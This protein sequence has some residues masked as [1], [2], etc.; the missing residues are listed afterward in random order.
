[1]HL[2]PNRHSYSALLGEE[3][4]SSL[5]LSGPVEYVLFREA[6]NSVRYCPL[7]TLLYL[8]YIFVISVRK[9]KKEEEKTESMKLMM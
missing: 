4:E 3:F 7:N 5:A 1:M 9:K 2:V 6:L 8:L